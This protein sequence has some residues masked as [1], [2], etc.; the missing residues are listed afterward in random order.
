MT[1]LNVGLLRAS[2]PL[3]V[4]VDGEGRILI[5]NH[6]C[7]VVTGYTFEEVRGKCAWEIFSAPEVAG[8]TWTGMVTSPKL[9]LPFQIGRA[10]A[11]SQTA[12]RC[13]R[14]EL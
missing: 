1:E 13:A 4:V 7:S 12:P 5:W 6:A 11:Y 9:M 10:M 8:S 14:C 2:A 3:M